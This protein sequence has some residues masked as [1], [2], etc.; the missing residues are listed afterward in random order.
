MNEAT[1]AI[2]LKIGAVP[3]LFTILFTIA[4]DNSEETGNLQQFI[5]NNNSEHIKGCKNCCTLRLELHDL[6]QALFKTQTDSNVISTKN[7]I[8]IEKYSLEIHDLNKKVCSLQK[9]KREL[10][11][12]VK[13]LQNEMH[14]MNPGAVCSIHFFAVL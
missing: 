5:E 8:R 10:E 6:K 3:T 4:D 12:K 2:S 7:K 1:G 9:D 11:S 14:R 13:K